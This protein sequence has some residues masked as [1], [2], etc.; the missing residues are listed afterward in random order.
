LDGEAGEVMTRNEALM[1]I[2]VIIGICFV[3]AVLIAIQ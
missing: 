1:I 2:A 3:A